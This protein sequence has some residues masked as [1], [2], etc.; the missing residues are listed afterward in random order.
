GWQTVRD[1]LI[2]KLCE[3]ADGKE[4]FLLCRS[5]ARR[6]KEEAMHGRFRKRLLKKLGSLG[7]RLK[8]ASAPLKHSQIHRQIGRMLE[9]NSRASRIYEIEV[10]ACPKR[11]SRVRLSIRLNRAF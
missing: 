10:V 4:T 1:G 3:G 6:I 5:E 2:V 7:R 8:N 11:A 9:A